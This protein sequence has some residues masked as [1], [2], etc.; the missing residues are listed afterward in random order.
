MKSEREY[1]QDI[2]EICR[3]MYARG[4]ISGSD[5]NV[6]VRLGSGR[7]L[8]T[9]SGINKGFLSLRD[10]IVTDMGGKKLQGDKKPTGE[11]YLHLEAYRQRPD[12]GAVVHAHPP[13]TIA[14]SLAGQK[15]PQCVL[16]EIVM[17]FGSIPTASYATPC[18]DEG[19]RAIAELIGDCDALIIERHG[20]ITVGDTVFTAYDRLEKVEHSA[21]VSA[22]ARQLGP[23]KPLPREEIDKLLALREKLG[24]KS[25]VYPC[26]SCG[27]CASSGGAAHTA[28]GLVSALSAELY[29]TLRE[30]L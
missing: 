7:L 28:H 24:L 29:R 6:S 23:V 19:P 30:K 3:R 10:L 14:F 5:G 27:L 18:T 8:S 1:R 12:I 17:I 16:P 21:Q 25:K 9:P 22:A 4:F 20:T 13:V 2:V 26:N 11:L 15:L